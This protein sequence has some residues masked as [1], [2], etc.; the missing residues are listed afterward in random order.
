MMLT[1]LIWNRAIYALASFLAL[2]YRWLDHR[3]SCLNFG[4]E[5]QLVKFKVF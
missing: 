4:E 3:R 2:P 5:A 1:K